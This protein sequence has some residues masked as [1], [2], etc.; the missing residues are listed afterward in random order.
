MLG[1]IRLQNAAVEVKFDIEEIKQNED[2]R[3]DFIIQ[4]KP[5]IAS[6]TSECAHRYVT[7]G[8]DEELSIALMAFNEAIDRFNGKGNFLLYAKMVIKA[9]LLDYFKSSVYREN[10]K[11]FGL[12]NEEDDEIE[13]LKDDAIQRYAE[14]YEQSIR[15]FEINELNAKLQDFGITFQ[16]L[17]KSSP[18]HLITRHYVNNAIQ[19]ILDNKELVEKIMSNHTL[20]LKEIE[21]SF[22]I[23]RKKIESYRKY[24]I[25]GIVLADSDLETLKEYLPFRK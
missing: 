13:E 5:F 7:Y 23:P 10:K 8:V 19:K 24:I 18:K 9:R 14:S 2:M 20:P 22:L 1:V 11:S 6:F 3:N 17:V 25:A 12:Y 21:K 4:Y 15:V 16:D